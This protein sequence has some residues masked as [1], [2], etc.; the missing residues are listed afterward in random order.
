MNITQI[1]PTRTQRIDQ[2]IKQRKVFSAKIQRDKASLEA[3]KLAFV[4]LKKHREEL[5]ARGI[6]STSAKRLGD[7]DF[8]MLDK[9]DALLLSMQ[10]LCDRCTR[11]TLNIAVVG[12]ARQGKSRLLRSLTGLNSTIIPDGGEGYCTGTLSKIRH[13]DGLKE[14]KGKVDFYSWHNFRDDILGSY[15]QNLD[16]PSLPITVDEFAQTPPPALPSEKRDSEIDKARYGHLRKD[17]FSNLQK[18]RQLLGKPSIEIGEQE[19]REYV[20]QDTKDGSGDK[21]ANYLAVKS[22]EISCSFPS[23]DIGK[24]MLID[25]PGLGDTNLIDAERLISTLKQEA[26]FVLFVRRPEAN[27]VWG[28]AHIKLYQTAREALGDLPLSRCSFMVLNRTKEGT[29]GGDNNYRCEKLQVE[30]KETPIQVERCAIADC[31]DPQEANTQILE[32]ILN[33]LV[34]KIEDIDSEYARACQK[35]LEQIQRQISIELEKADKA[36]AHYGDGDLLFEQLFEKFW[37][38]LTND[39]ENL[40][41]HFSDRRHDQDSEFEERVKEA[42][43]DCREDTGIPANVK[44]IAER[45]N[46]FGSYNTAYNEFL[47]EIRTHF[48]KHFL[49][50][51][52][53][54]QMSLESRKT[55]VAKALKIRLGE[56]GDGEGSEFLKAITAKLPENANILK[57]GFQSISDFNVS[58]AGKIQRQVRENLEKLR[59]DANP[60]PFSDVAMD[61]LK[62]DAKLPTQEELILTAL[63]KLHKEAA[64]KSEQ[65]LQKILCEPSLDAYFMVEEFVDR[66]LRAKGVQLEWRI[67]LRKVSSQVWPEFKEMENRVQ[68]QQIWKQL[69]MRAKEVNGMHERLFLN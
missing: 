69:V 46:L 64:D 61:E 1:N 6:D 63:N 12:Y 33:Y 25:L 19:I 55:L 9:I 35:Y 28:E 31:S 51:D 68:Q 62:V 41:T 17:Y 38:E 30:L 49:S 16:L 37:Q 50:L 59:P 29:E 66:I 56:L 27:A 58:W 57:L 3:R 34:E 47:H 5:L 22:V 36:L 52:S 45:R 67:F 53:G 21:I 48:L 14:A 2:I 10:Q 65:S 15:Y 11:D 8:T 23:E 24:I 60:V 39:L 26:D 54:M 20:T 7:I 42:I 40:L 32:P 18:Y 44:D 43:A 13:E 4:N